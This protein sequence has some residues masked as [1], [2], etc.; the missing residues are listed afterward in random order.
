[1]ESEKDHLGSNIQ[2]A[3]SQ[4]HVNA[5]SFIRCSLLVQGYLSLVMRAGF[6]VM[7]KAKHQSSQWK[8]KSEVKSMLI[9]FFDIKETVYNEFVVAAQTV[10]FAYYCDFYGD[11]MKMCKDFTLNFGNSSSK[12]SSHGSLFHG[13]KCIP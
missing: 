7:T 10:N 8:M 3:H 9:I 2:K 5:R 11:C 4:Q 13:T 12:I 6:T 1:M